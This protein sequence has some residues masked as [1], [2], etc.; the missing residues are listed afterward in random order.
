[1]RLSTA[2]CA[3]LLA[4]APACKRKSE[5]SASLDL[6]PPPATAPAV[7]ANVPTPTPD[8][9]PV[10]TELGPVPD[11]L[12]SSVTLSRIADSFRRPLALEVAPGDDSGRLYVVEQGGRI[13]TMRGEKVSGEP[14]LDIRKRVSRG[15]NEQGLLGLAFHPEFAENRRFFVNYTG[16]KGET[17]VVE[18]KAAGPEKV[19]AGSERL[20]LR[21][22]QPWGNHNGGGLEFGPD[23]KL[24]IGTGDGGAAGDPK[25]S[26]QDPDSLLGKMLR[27]D[28]DGEAP[29]KP[30]IVQMGLRNPWRYDFDAA[31]GDLYIADVGQDRWEWI[32]VVAADAIE[33]KNFGW[34]ITEGSQC[35]RS[36]DCDKS[37][38]T[39][40]AIEYDH[41]TGCSITGGEVYRGSA[42]PALRGHYFYADYCTALIRSF[43][44]SEDGVRQH[45]DWKPVLDPD[46]KLASIS[47]FGH[48]AAGELYIISLEGPIYKIV[49]R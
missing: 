26:G 47:S 39:G 33:G 45:W 48:D 49:P 15:H 23:G 21:I 24:Y 4:A 3:A 22:E 40:P 6:A 18:M 13:W 28:V 11:P 19:A 43:R 8:P 20:W 27:I 38:L 35:F 34:N 9:G 16:A 31:T 32:N 2:C 7:D 25:G 14:F 44:W 12:A 30:E 5:R 17:R 41:D 10:S 37:G 42:I 29:G 1:M 36:S 46:F